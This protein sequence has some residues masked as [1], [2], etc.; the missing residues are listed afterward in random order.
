M[1]PL[2][3]LRTNSK[4]SKL[5]PPYTAVEPLETSLHD[6][7]PS[8]SEAEHFS[9]WKR[10][11]E[12]VN[13]VPPTSRYAYQPLREA[14]DQVRLIELQPGALLDTL[15]CRV[16][17][18]RLSD[19][20][21]YE[22]LSY[23]WGN[24]TVTE[25]MVCEDGVLNITINLAA[26]LRRLRNVSKTRV[27]WVDA[28]SINQQDVR[29]RE[30]Q[31]GLMARLYHQAQEVIIWLGHDLHKSAYLAFN[32]VAEY[33][34]FV[35]NEIERLPS[36]SPTTR[37]PQFSEIRA[38]WPNGPVKVDER[39]I[40]AIAGL[41]DCSWFKRVW[42]LQEA[43]LAAKASVAWGTSTISFE[44]L[45]CFAQAVCNTSPGFAKRLNLWPVRYTYV[46]VW[47]TYAC[48]TSWKDRLPFRFALN[49]QGRLDDVLSTSCSRNTSEVR[50]YIY[51]MLGHPAFLKKDGT[52][53]VSPDYAISFKDLCHNVT[54][55]VIKERSHL[56]IFSLIR[57]E[58][59]DQLS[60]TISWVPNFQKISRRI[61]YQMFSSCRN[62]LAQATVNGNKL[63]CLG[64]SIGTVSHVFDG[65]EPVQ[66]D[67]KEMVQA[68]DDLWT[69]IRA[70][71]PPNRY[72]KQNALQSLACVT[73]TK[74]FAVVEDWSTLTGRDRSVQN[75][76]EGLSR[77]L[78]AIHPT[79][80][81]VRT[82]LVP[83]L[84]D[85]GVDPIKENFLHRAKHVCPGRS[86]F[87]TL[88]GHWGLGPS[89]MLPEDRCCVLYGA[90]V[91]YVL[92][93]WGEEGVYKLVGEAY[94]LGM[95]E[96]QALDLLEKGELSEEWFTIC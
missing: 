33:A 42:V 7:L 93:P 14:S 70:R 26:G 81:N 39:G 51:S 68:L 47:S 60:Q 64:I 71:K 90:R 34:A 11:T 80:P 73:T 67:D 10:P 40:E 29:E 84:E 31:V 20:P 24:P 75:T 16:Q 13:K 6:A 49:N 62:R 88:D 95:M 94:V 79:D 21:V 38:F 5:E 66:N 52:P 28:I 48:S 53:F 92:R 54:V 32:L 86:F 96:G 91:A 63:K 72:G 23:V 87:T 69:A 45:V 15:E 36:V 83:L 74:S 30:V 12:L 3:K 4:S 46:N 9:I 22:A 43:G 8:A 37:K 50:D 58:S 78:V 77:S 1:V 82:G 61:D 35:A 56:S 59:G 76:M 25:P 41:Y 44:T 27:L 65:Y 55:A 85:A 18:V 89:I 19:K 57:H 2:I 17:T